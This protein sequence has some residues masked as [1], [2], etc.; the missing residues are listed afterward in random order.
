[1]AAGVFYYFRC[2]FAF[3]LSKFLGGEYHSKRYDGQ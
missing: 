3:F 1:M 2:F